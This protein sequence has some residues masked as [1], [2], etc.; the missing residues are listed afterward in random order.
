M[1]ANLSTYFVG[2][3]GADRFQHSLHR[4]H[5]TYVH[6]DGFEVCLPGRQ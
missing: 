6:H 5:W 3:P 1:E 4:R 2:I